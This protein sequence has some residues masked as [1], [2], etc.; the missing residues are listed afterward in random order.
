MGVEYGESF[1]E[2]EGSVLQL[3]EWVPGPEGHYPELRR[4]RH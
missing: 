3:Q 2:R 4:V 1:D